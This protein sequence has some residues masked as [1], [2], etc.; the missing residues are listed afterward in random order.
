MS[1]LDLD[2]DLDLADMTCRFAYSPM[3]V[4]THILVHEVID[5]RGYSSPYHHH[6]M[7][8][9]ERAAYD[10]PRTSLLQEEED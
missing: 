2:Q 6:R 10:H 7:I 8:Q 5:E 1:R 3:L 9:I 4:L